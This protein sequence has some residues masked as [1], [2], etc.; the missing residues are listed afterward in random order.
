MQQQTVLR[1]KETS[2]YSRQHKQLNLEN[3]LWTS[4]PAQ[5]AHRAPNVQF[6]LDSAAVSRAT[7]ENRSGMPAMRTAGQS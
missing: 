1:I 7:D 4:R 2:M 6:R 3:T 5:Y